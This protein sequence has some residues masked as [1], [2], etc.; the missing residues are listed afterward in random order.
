MPLMNFRYVS[1][2]LLLLTSPVTAASRGYYR[3]PAIHENTV[4]FTAEGDLWKVGVEGGTAVRLTTHLGQETHAAI[5]PDG[6]RIAFS[7]RYEGAAEVYVMPLAGGRPERV[8]FDGETATVVGWKGN[9]R[10]VYA[11]THFSTLPDTQLVLVDPRTRRQQLVPLSQA[12]DGSWDASGKT[13]FFTRWN[14][15]FSSTKRYKGGWAQNV[16]K[17]A[18]GAKEAVPLTGG[19]SGTSR[20]PMWHRGRV[21]FVT[22]RDGTLNLWSMD[23]SGKDLKQHTFHK[24]FDVLSPSMAGGKIVYQHGADLRVFDAATNTDRLI[25][26]SLASDFDQTRPRWVKKPMDYLSAF[27]LSPGG[28]RVALTARG[29]VFVRPVSG[30]RLVEVTRQPGVRYRSAKF[31]PDGKTLIAIS[32]ETGEME[33]WKLPADGIGRRTPITSKGTIFRNAAT[34]SPDGK[35]FAYADKNGRLWIVDI[36]TG[37]QSKVAESDYGEWSAHGQFTRIAW[38]PD[39]RWLAYVDAAPN[40]IDRIFLYE[41]ASDKARPVTTDRYDSYSPAWSPDGKWLYFLSDRH[42]ASLV[43]SP[44]GPLQPEP[45]F[46]SKAG[47]YGVALRKGQPWPFARANEIKRR[48]GGWTFPFKIRPVVRIDFDGIERRT[49]KVPAAWG[50]YER[51]AVAGKQL[52]WTTAGDPGKP[53]RSLMT[54]AIGSRK[55][56]TLVSG[57][58]GYRTSADGKKVLVRKGD[59]LYVFRLGTSAP[60][61]LTS[62][63]VDLKGWTFAVDPKEEWKQMFV[64]AWRMERDYFYDRGLHGRDWKAIRDRHLPLLD[65]V[66]DRAELNDLLEQAVGEL[67]ALHIFVRGGEHREGMD[68][69]EPASLGAVLSRDDKAGGYRV[70]RNYRTDPDEPEKLPPLLKADV[71][72]NEGDV[73]LEINGVSTLSVPHPNFLLRNQAGKQVRLRIRKPTSGKAVD[74]IVTPVTQK[75]AAD[76]RYSH[77]E[78]GRRRRVE[79]EA[80]GTIGYV[81]LRAMGTANIAEWA[82]NYYPV[83]NRQGLIIDVRNNRGGNIDSW[84]LGRL[85][86]KAWFYWQPRTGKPFWNMQYAFRGHIVVLCNE[87]TASD[88]EAFTEGFRRLKLGKVIGTRTWG[89][90]IW[91]S[92]NN[93]LVDKGI[94]SAA[95]TGVYGPERKWLIEGHGVEPDITV[96][97]SPHATF[98]GKDAQLEAAIRH[99]RE[100]IRKDPRPVPKPPAYPRFGK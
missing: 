35:R 90:E 28:D 75:A 60:G 65:R 40:T 29:R 68:K 92:M 51:L 78:I 67:R 49:R 79:Q 25:P 16:W 42:L 99:L 39:G 86:R 69:I 24:W 84:I 64:D 59:D 85:L 98:R 57:I 76:M 66:T 3:F 19:Y 70:A 37:R 77:W 12:R 33:F 46:T 91:L 23:D 6:K 50:N 14:K 9:G 53:E 10:I 97:N 63:R 5:S 48:S 55:P 88:G 72:I 44:W 8:T 71:E 61:N 45:Y 38:S 96:D 21:F 18:A 4:V 15:Q 1:I 82:R 100:E 36:A 95:Q 13:L 2:A 87:K 26:I 94:A 20:T 83:F 93:R 73:I 17:F 81:H 7:A 22:D 89:G 54:L 41:V 34:P 74:V 27:E 58:R 43:R 47:I 56:A 31:L 30:G 32:D 62:G 80:K 11:T 52:V